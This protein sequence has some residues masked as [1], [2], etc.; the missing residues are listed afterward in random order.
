MSEPPNKKSRPPKYTGK[1][2]IDELYDVISSNP[3]FN[4]EEAIFLTRE[5]GEI[6]EPRNPLGDPVST[7]EP[8]PI[9]SYLLRYLS[10]VKKCATNKL[11]QYTV[12]K[13]LIEPVKKIVNNVMNF[14]ESCRIKIKGFNEDCE[15]KYQLYLV[16]SSELIQ[17]IKESKLKINE[18]LSELHNEVDYIQKLIDEA[19]YDENEELN[20][21]RILSLNEDDKT[22][23]AYFAL[24]KP[25]DV[26]QIGLVNAKM[27]EFYKKSKQMY[28]DPARRSELQDILTEFDIIKNIISIYY[29]NEEDFTDVGKYEDLRF[30]NVYLDELQA[31]T[32][33]DVA[34]RNTD[35]KVLTAYGELEAYLNKQK[36]IQKYGYDPDE[37]ILYTSITSD[38]ESSDDESSDFNKKLINSIVE[39]RHGVI[40]DP[41]QSLLNAKEL[42]KI[43]KESVLKQYPKGGKK[44]KKTKKI[45]KSKKT[46]K[47][48]KN[49]KNKQ[50]KRRQKR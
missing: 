5:L 18:L 22:S 19:I 16:E 33:K 46:K 48:R 23:I 38:D 32:K 26:G 9:Q 47:V 27:Q 43:Y 28:D 3:T 34:R 25:D 21:S 41:T 2:E 49:R 12:V 17:Q 7:K 44:S 20:M 24:I 40:G 8:T 45:K 36:R 14:S 11:L 39:E 37:N 1:E 15:K 35:S 10:S 31:D 4:A 42:N 6:Y 29:T 13:K 30:G 50:S